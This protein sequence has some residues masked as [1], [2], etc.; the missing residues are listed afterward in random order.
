MLWL[1]C[2]PV[3]V[4]PVQLLAWELPYAAGAALKK[5]KK[6]KTANNNNNKNSKCRMFSLPLLKFFTAI[7]GIMGLHDGGLAFL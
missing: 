3:A 1:W 5:N 6:T 7:Q 2:R 4:A